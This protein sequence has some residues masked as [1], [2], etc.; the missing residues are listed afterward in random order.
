MTQLNTRE[1]RTT[2]ARRIP[3]LRS[4]LASGGSTA[5]RTTERAR[6]SVEPCVARER[7]LG[8]PLKVGLSAGLGV[9]LFL[10]LWAPDASRGSAERLQPAASRRLQGLSIL[11]PESSVIRGVSDITGWLVPDIEDGQG[12]PARADHPERSPSVPNPAAGSSVKAALADNGSRSTAGPVPTRGPAARAWVGASG[13]SAGSEGR[14]AAG[15]SSQRIGSGNGLRGSTGV[16]RRSSVAAAM[17]EEKSKKTA[18]A[19]PRI[20]VQDPVATFQP[21]PVYPPSALKEELPG[22]V[23]VELWVTPLGGVEGLKVLH[24]EPPGRFEEAVLEAVKQWR[25]IPAR[26]QDGKPIQAYERF[27]Y[28]F[29][30]EAPRS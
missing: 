9:F 25:F 13:R 26:D 10:G 12:Q 6:A 20:K 18:A 29:K 23:E 7:G 28:V 17:E 15:K 2:A 11:T 27:E 30:L 4:P 22:S 24:A 3:P 14:G 1:I 5:H 16:K 8:R 19:R 21:K